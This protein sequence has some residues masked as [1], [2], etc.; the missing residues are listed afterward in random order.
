M[1]VASFS[2]SALGFSKSPLGIIA[3]FIVL[4]YGFASLVV[5]FGDG[6]GENVVLLVYFMVLFPVLVF[7]GFLWLVAKHHNKLY[8]PSDFKDEENF[9]RTQISSAA[10]LAMAV[11]KTE[12]E[13]STEINSDEISILFS[14][15]RSKSLRLDTKEKRILWV[16]DNP[17]NN[18][19]IKRAFEAQGITVILARSTK[20]ALT[21]IESA[22]YSAII[23][24]MGR[25]EGPKEGYV[26][27]ET[28]RKSKIN[29]PF[30]IF[31]GSNKEEHRKMAIDK[32]ATSS[33][34]K[35]QVLFQEVMQVL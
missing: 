10:H 3:L 22:S 15:L 35:P 25:E 11:A 6:I 30:F 33:T 19:H 2:K 7:C 12:S 13:S 31:A 8:G 9:I 1:D 17:E 21:Q 23:S 28:L 29:T 32:G 20:E 4:I 27:L 26:L 18:T 16:D 14:Q 5:T 34:N 24:D